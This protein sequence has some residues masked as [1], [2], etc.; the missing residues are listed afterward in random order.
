MTMEPD[1]GAEFFGRKMKNPLILAS[2][3]QGV[4]KAGLE[5]V[6][7]DGA[8]AVTAKSLSI[9]PRKGHGTPVLVETECGMLNAVGYS[10]PGIEEGI[11]EFSGWERSEPLI[12]S[13]TGKDE[14]EFSALAEKIEEAKSELNCSAIELAL[15][16]PHTPGYGL[17]AGQADP[18]MSGKI[19]EAVCKKTSLPV[20]VKL[21]PSIPGEVEAAKNAEAAGASAINMGNTLGPGMRIDIERRRPVLSFRMGGV[22]GPAIRPVAIRC[23]YNIYEEAGIPIIG[24]GGVNDGRDAIEMMMAGASFVGVGTAMYFRG[25][26]AFKKIDG[27]MRGWMKEREIKKASEL[28]GIAHE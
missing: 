26:D 21:S 9:E 28:V 8:G 25:R 1:V 22:S 19:T 18:K 16:C 20:I 12:L 4:A 10:N 27:E 7:R 13:I 17:M 14:K 24:T 15:S 23:V 11:K 5:A 6:A 3:I 2:G